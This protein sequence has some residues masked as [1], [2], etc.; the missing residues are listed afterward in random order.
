VRS[1]LVELRKMPNSF[2]VSDMVESILPD[3]R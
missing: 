1:D 3:H 2:W